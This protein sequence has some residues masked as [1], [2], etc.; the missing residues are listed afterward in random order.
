MKKQYKEII[1]LTIALLT[2]VGAI[3]PTSAAVNL[4]PVSTYIVRTIDGME[5]ALEVTS[6]ETGGVVK[7]TFGYAVDGFT[8]ELPDSSVPFLLAQPGVLSVEKD[9]PMGMLA[10]QQVES[11]T[12]S[13]GIDRIDQRTTIPASD[14]AYKS[15]YGYR[16]AGS[17]STIYVVDTGVYPHADFGN[18]LS[19]SGYTG[20]ADGNGT[21]DCYGHG[22]HVAS[23]AAG[24]QYGIAKNAT[25]V[26][27]RVLSCAGSGSVSGVIAGLDW[28]LSPMNTNSHTQAVVN[29]SLGGAAS[30]ALDEAIGRITNAGMTMVVS[31]GNENSDA[32]TRS[33]ARAPSAITVGATDRTDA[34][35]SYSN[36]GTCVDINAPG[37]SI[38][39]AWITNSTSTNTISGTSMAAPHV[40][41]AV[42]I[43]QISIAVGGPVVVVLT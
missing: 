7:K 29:M 3:V 38:T 24:T 14:P 23:T 39:G 43:R 10:V 15:A 25:I 13:W 8:V 32:C 31:A 1:G 12:P 37:T 41:G 11:P 19:Q 18:R 33:P 21:S 2:T 17:G 30:G 20:F 16:S 34:K 42:A 6:A 40:T 27:V 9:A 28:I 4:G 35:A 22:T 5:L 26:P 36:F